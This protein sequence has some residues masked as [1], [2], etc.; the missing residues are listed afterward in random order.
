MQ[1]LTHTL[2]EKK[3]K[4]CRG[5]IPVT[6]FHIARSLDS[7]QYFLRLFVAARGAALASPRSSPT[8]PTAT[9]IIIAMAIVCFWKMFTETVHAPRRLIGTAPAFGSIWRRLLTV[10]KP[11]AKCPFAIEQQISNWMCVSFQ[12]F[13]SH[14]VQIRFHLLVTRIACRAFFLLVTRIASSW[15]ATTSAKPFGDRQCHGNTYGTTQTMFDAYNGIAAHKTSNFTIK[16]YRFQNVASCIR[17]LKQ[18]EKRGAEP[19]PSRYTV[20]ATLNLF[21]AP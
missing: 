11:E 3:K 18:F 15:F 9:A 17:S 8:T 10:K 2:V 6:Q 13:G 5:Q 16:E 19:T 1:N 21:F 20:Y 14:S 12:F 7:H 4:R